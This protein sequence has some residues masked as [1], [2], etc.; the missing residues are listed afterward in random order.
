MRCSHTYTNYYF[1]QFIYFNFGL[2]IVELLKNW[3]NHNRILIS[4]RLKIVFLTNCKR[5][6][7]LLNHLNCKQLLD[8]QFRLPKYKRVA[9][10]KIKRMSGSL[11]GLEI[12]DAHNYQRYLTRKL[13]Y[14]NKDIDYALPSNICKKFT[15]YRAFRRFYDRERIRLDKKLRWLE[16]RQK[17]STCDHKIN[18]YCTINDNTFDNDKPINFTF[19][20]PTNTS[21]P[22]QEINLNSNDYKNYNYNFKNLN[23]KRLVNLSQVHIPTD[24]QRLLQLGEG[25]PIYNAERSIVEIVNKF[26][27]KHIEDNFMRLSVPKDCEIRNKLVPLVAGIRNAKAYKGDVDSI[28]LS[29]LKT[30]KLFIKQNQDILFTR[31]D[32]GNTVVAINK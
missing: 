25:L 32:K 26:I 28:I 8:L 30:T 21:L 9:D 17:K 5:R 7:L 23:D 10:Q 29:S 22:S 13:Y 2:E 11:I 3:I 1:F 24:V 15:Q 18:Y 12:S 6:D 20:K 4:T 31:A 27:V 16:S 14:L 19:N